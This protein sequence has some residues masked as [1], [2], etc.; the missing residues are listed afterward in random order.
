MQDVQRQ[1]HK[2][3]IEA[4]SHYNDGFTAWMCKKEL[5]ELKAELDEMLENTPHFSDLEEKFLAEQEK[6]KI[7][8]ILKK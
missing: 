3:Y 8:K 5:L 4:I 2:C 1:I 7:I 6:K